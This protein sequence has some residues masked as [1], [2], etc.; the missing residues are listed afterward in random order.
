MKAAS[1]GLIERLLAERIGLDPASVGDNLIANGVRA[2]MESLGLNGRAEYERALLGPGD[3]LQALVEEVV[4]PES[5]FFRDDRPFEALRDHARAGWAG[6]PSRPPLSALSL[7]CAGGEEPYSIAMA[8]VEAGLPPD[9]VRVDAV[10]VSARSLARAIEGTYGANSFRGTPP[11]ARARFF[12]E[13]RGRYSVEPAIRSAV[14]FHLGN[15]LDPGLLAGRPPF[16]VVFCRNLLIYFDAPARAR[17]FAGLARL[18]AAGGLL[19]LGHADRGDDSTASPFA[20]LAAR[21]SFAYRKAK[22]GEA[23]GRAAPAR[24]PAAA[25]PPA[26]APAPAKTKPRP[27][28]AAPAGEEGR[29]AAVPKRPAPGPGPAAPAEA[30]ASA[31]DRAATLAD[32]GEYA[33]ARGLIDRAVAEGGPSAR[34]SSLL[35]LIR[36]ASGDRDG[37]ER[38]FLKAI[39]LDPQDAEA[40]L[41]LAAL[42]ARRGD[43]AAE[44]GYRRRA[45]R[46]LARKGGPR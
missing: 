31:L 5:W 32:R 14:H 8:A 40:L 17:A 20:P 12:R 24:K 44:A 2:R 22:A 36:Q 11:A 42:A 33:E 6:D 3:E 13:H 1:T 30:P 37:A 19:F 28:A 27:A 41:S 34:A 35:G 38:H 18:T 39:Y 10:D 45:G 15:L 29:A 25:P 26:P 4:I 46:V 16:D 7:P 21:G 43:L 23:P 9:R